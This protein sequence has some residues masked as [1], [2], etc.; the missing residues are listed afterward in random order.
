MD[1]VKKNMHDVKRG[2]L[3]VGWAGKV[4][5]DTVSADEKGPFLRDAS[6]GKHYGD[7]NGMVTVYV[8][9]VRTDVVAQ[10]PGKGGREAVRHAVT[11]ADVP[12]CPQ[13]RTAK[14]LTLWESGTALA[15]VTCSSCASILKLQSRYE[16]KRDK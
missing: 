12:V 4:P 2:S 14:G 3:L 11:F 8:P 6:G 5:A 7:G 9:T 15:S 10:K 1:T 16:P 13:G